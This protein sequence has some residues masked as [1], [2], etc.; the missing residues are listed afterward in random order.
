[1]PPHDKPGE[2][3]AALMEREWATLA[4]LSRAKRVWMSLLE[5]MPPKV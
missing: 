2:V 4:L 1:M 3:F 5:A